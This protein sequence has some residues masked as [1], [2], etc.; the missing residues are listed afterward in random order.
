MGDELGLARAWRLIAFHSW[1][2]GQAAASQEAWERSVEHA[3][4]AGSR[5]DELSG[6]AWLA[7]VAVFGPTPVRDA[8]RRC[9]EILEQVKGDLLAET[10]VLGLT[11]WL[12]VFEGRF[13]EARVLQAR[14][15]AVFEELGL[16]LAVAWL[17]QDAG[18]LEM[19]AGDADAAERV[20]RTGFERLER[21]GARADLGIVGTYLAQALYLQ[22]RYEEA[23]HLALSIEEIDPPAILEGAYARSTRAKAI[24]KL[25]RVEEGE[26]LARKAMALIDRTDFPIDRGNVR[27]DLAE[28]LVMAKRPAEAA[29]L[30][31]EAV[32]L[33]EEKGNIVS[34]QRGRALLAE[35]DR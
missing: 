32:R 14:R 1:G 15:T 17:A 25:G 11:S 23:E 5:R 26:Q 22:K 34:A 2:E 33:N 10:D 27:M 20:L 19:L 31:G 21:A 9:D 4:R 12:H 3:R 7:S 29:H 8:Q 30:L 28:V 35:L 6:L 18:F 24:A 16:E 13:D